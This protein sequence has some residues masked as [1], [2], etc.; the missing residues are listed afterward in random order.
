MEDKEVCK[1]LI[2]V[3]IAYD[4]MINTFL[5]IPDKDVLVV[6][7][8]KSGDSIEINGT[9]L[10]DFIGECI[11]NDMIQDLVKAPITDFIPYKP[12]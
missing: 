5:P 2:P 3:F 10:W 1:T 9:D 6:H 12:H 4:G 11:R 7:D 8:S